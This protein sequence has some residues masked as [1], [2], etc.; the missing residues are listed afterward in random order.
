MNGARLLTRP[1]HSADWF[2][3]LNE[4]TV[5]QPPTL[6]LKGFSDIRDGRGQHTLSLNH[7]R[8]A[9]DAE[10]IASPAPTGAARPL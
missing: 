8:L 1:V 10:L 7:H 2:Q 5:M 3:H 9:D 6:L 4:C